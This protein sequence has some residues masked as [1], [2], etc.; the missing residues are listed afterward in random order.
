MKH[1]R[2]E[3]INENVNVNVNLDQKVGKPPYNA[4]DAWHVNFLR[5]PNFEFTFVNYPLLGGLPLGATKVMCPQVCQTVS[6]C[7]AALRQLSVIS[8]RRPSSSRLS[9]LWFSA[10]AGLRSTSLPHGSTSVGPERSG[11][12]HIPAPSLRSH[13]SRDNGKRHL[14]KLLCSRGHYCNGM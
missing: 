5:Q 7:F 2:A 12:A 4:A 13:H 1:N 9:L 11:T 8:S 6:R 14:P 10:A 3:L